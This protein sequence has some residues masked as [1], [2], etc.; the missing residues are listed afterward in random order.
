MKKFSWKVFSV[1]LSLLF[2]FPSPQPVQSID[3]PQDQ[4]YLE[5]FEDGQ[6]QGWDLESGWKIT[7]DGG[8]MVLAGQGHSWADSNQK[9]NDCTL[10]FRIKVLK[11]SIHLVFHMNDAGRYYISF[12]ASGS[13]V[14]KQYWPETF[15]HGLK[16]SS[17]RHAAGTWNQV[18][19]VGAGA[20]ITFRVNGKTEWTF[21]DAKPLLEGKFAFETLDGAQAYVDDIVVSPG[22]ISVPA[23]PLINITPTFKSVTPLTISTPTTKPVVVV[24][25]IASSG[26][27]S[28][29]VQTNGPQ[30]GVINTIE[31][32]PVNPKLIYAGGAGG[33]YKSINA[34]E[35]WDQLSHFLTTYGTVHNL[36]INPNSP[37]ILYAESGK[38][39]KSDDAGETWISLFNGQ[40]IN[41]VAIDSN[42]SSNLLVGTN[43]GKVWL[44]QNGGTAWQNISSNLP[45]YQIKVLAL[46]NKN[47]LWAGT[48]ILGGFGNGYLYRS[49]NNGN[50]WS[51]INLS[52]S[53]TSEI[54]TIF[55]NPKDRDT[56]YV[57]LRNIHNE[58]FNPQS[59]I[60]LVKTIDG[61]N[62]WQRLYLPF[63][64]AMVNLMG[65][66]SS[67]STLYLGT[68]GQAYYSKD[69]GQVW[70]DMSPVGRNGDMFDIAGDPQDENK[71]Y[72]PRRAF[73]IV[74]SINGGKD[75]IPI[76]EGLI[77]TTVSLIELGDSSGSTIYA[78]SVDGEGTYKSTDYG[79]TWINITSGG[80]THPWADEL[81]VN[82][83]DQQTIW[84]VA[85]VGEVFT[86]QDGGKT[87][88]KKID[89]YGAGFRAGTVT[90]AAI[91][92]SNSNIVYAVKSG[93]GIYK[94]T[95]RVQGWNFLHQSEVDYTYSIVVNP[96]NPD[97]VFSGDIPKPF[98][99]R[100][101]VQRSNDG[102]ITW[103]SV[104]IVPDSSGISSV[105]IDPQ[106][107]KKVYAG[108]TG[109]TENGGGQ[110]YRTLDNGDTW[111]KLNPHFIMSTVWG[112]PQLT[113]DLR[114]SS[115]V[116]A[117][118]WLA[119]TW[120]TIDA[121][122]NWTKLDNA[123]IS[124]T[125]LSIDPNDSNVIYAADRTAPKLWKSM[126]AGKTWIETANFS[127]DRAFLVNRVLAVKNAVY[128]STFGPGMHD[129]KLYR[130]ADKGKTW[131]D[132]TN[133]LPRSVLDIAVD[134]ANSK[135]IYVTTHIH[136]AFQSNDGG[137]SWLPLANFPDIGAYD[138]ELD[139]ASP[140]IL[141]AA[142]LDGHVP[143]WVMPGGYSFKNSAG[144]YKSVDSG[145]TWQQILSTS[146]ECRAIRIH[147]ANHNLL[148]VSSLSDGFSVSNNGGGSWTSY[149]TG[150]YSRNLTSVLV[151]ENKVY[152]GTQGFGIYSGNLN[153]STGKVEWDS[154]RS[155]K[156]IP[157]TFNLQVQID[158][159]DSNKIYVGSNPGGLY[160][161]DDGGKTW[162][163][164]NFLTPSV[165]VDDPFRQGYYTFAINPKYTKEVWVGTWG[166]GIYKSYDGQDFNIGANGNDR[167][168][169]GKHINALL[170]HSELGL[171]AATEEGVFYTQDGGITWTDWHSG[172]GSIQV[173]T[174]NQF[175]NGTVLCGTAGYEFYMR[176][177]TDSQWQQVNA[178]ANFGTFWPIWNN[179]PLYQYSQLLFHPQ[180]AKTIYFGT[181]PEGI[182]KSV[183]GGSTWK[184]YNVGW[185]VDG[186][187]TLVFHPQNSNIIYAG[188]Y[189]GIN[190]SQ[191]SGKHWERWNT[192][193][194]GEQWVFSIAFDPSNPKIIYACS[195]NGENEGTGRTNFHGTVMKS[196]DGGLTWL[197]ITNGLDLNNEFY[198]IIVDRFNSKTVYL[199]TQ[200]DGVFVSRNG[201]ES[202]RSF[203]EGLTNLAA[204]TN[205]NNVTNTMVLSEDGKVLYFG[206]SGSGLF[207]RYL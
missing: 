131:T 63:T 140:N 160:R 137:I 173:R 196:K 9:C 125:S 172:L 201:G 85:D 190:R 69:G 167:K 200:R 106:N 134:P 109:S 202:W 13:M 165:V 72:L 188:T 166:M 162:A 193:W 76:N 205:G 191:D 26:S 168:M 17:A 145:K 171:I 138:I 6:A 83:V 116:Y 159:K 176:R 82:P 133:G 55:V 23:A 2:I 197:P 153:S 35:R 118:T 79:N 105:V 41:C 73:G 189:N 57:G 12:N 80:I 192:G 36:I 129:G 126:D 149:N 43:N 151:N 114:N 14:S 180:D 121:G 68:G 38:L 84:E 186:V 152:V 135:K 22:G 45:S 90:A 86:S 27:S 198:K 161:S 142:G 182:F 67:R 29:W 203:N 119:G 40:P 74:K 52:Q 111:S 102:G 163:D 37:N 178:F 195:K 206:S 44:S 107:P 181:F 146:N 42:N 59:D 169:I 185:T 71:L 28:S 47:V 99:Q 65:T 93:F 19:I 32:D 187:F 4:V 34:G 150:L 123:P 96:T 33:I 78:S 77:N 136:G 64:D 184:E 87:W 110:I 157:D 174:L 75:W 207:R 56:V 164:K 124:S 139:D 144:V 60:Y 122:K 48:G 170:F 88:K 112:Q 95:N 66:I 204:G 183:D 130:S 127:A 132:I 39:F 175:S 128:A 97:I 25:A 15:Q 143:D 92:P 62:N 1:F 58:M 31:V 120:K 155:N 81:T 50:S 156:P 46:G 148:L 115:V 49:Q 100:A 10:A 24:P 16:Q 8:N 3:Q 194:P 89:S 98:Q 199:A 101:R 70:I 141:Y 147:P 5:D 7:S 108:S 20:K 117:A 53:T 103:S 30:G 54:Q 91:S 94:S 11:G 104:L 18:E 61:G 154:S 158:P 177:S 113:G 51:P 21:T 179:R